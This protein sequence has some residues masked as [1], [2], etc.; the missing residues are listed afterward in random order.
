MIPACSKSVSPSSHPPLG[1]S[2]LAFGSPLY[3]TDI[4]KIF[5]GI[6]TPSRNATSLIRGLTFDVLVAR[7]PIRS[8]EQ[9]PQEKGPVRTEVARE[10]LP[11]QAKPQPPS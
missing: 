3:C 8:I 10:G 9:F 5:P 11:L 2:C 4:V 1:G 7:L 6:F